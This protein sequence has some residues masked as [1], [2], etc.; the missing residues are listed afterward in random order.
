MAIA[1][2]APYTR[3]SIYAML[4]GNNEALERAILAIQSRQTEDEQAAQFTKHQNGMGWNAHDA[5]IGGSLAQ[6]ITKGAAP[7]AKGGY[8][9]ALG[10]TLTD[11]QRVMALRMIRK[12]TGQLLAVAEANGKAVDFNDNTP[13]DEAP[14]FGG[15]SKFTKA[16]PAPRGLDDDDTA[17]FD[18]VDF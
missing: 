9:K 13:M 8:G 3:A 10:R 5:P 6:W 1:T 15:S 11:K 4:L 17:G 12:Y 18:D 14:A 2:L 7:R 16:T